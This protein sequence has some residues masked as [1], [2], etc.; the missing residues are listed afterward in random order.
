MAEAM[1]KAV[2]APKRDGKQESESRYLMKFGAMTE[3][4]DCGDALD[5]TLMGTMVTK[6]EY[7]ALNQTMTDGKEKVK[8]WRDNKRLCAILCWGKTAIMVWRCKR[9]QSLRII[10]M[11]G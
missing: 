1:S 5:P 10:P 3:Y 8:L 7:D 2:S 6:S 9:R 11:G 4:Y